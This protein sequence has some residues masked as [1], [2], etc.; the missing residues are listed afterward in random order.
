MP[1]N[2]FNPQNSIVITF[3]SGGVIAGFLLSIL[4]STFIVI[5]GIKI[6][7]LSTL[8]LVFVHIISTQRETALDKE[9][10]TYG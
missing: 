5:L 4:P 9:E 8:G 7:I 2:P 3:Y 1:K 10:I 6:L